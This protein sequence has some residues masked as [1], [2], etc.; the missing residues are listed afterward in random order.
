MNG[1]DEVL[2][3]GGER[4]PDG[5]WA[6]NSSVIPSGAQSPVG[7]CRARQHVG[8][9]AAPR[10]SPSPSPLPSPALSPPIAKSPTNIAVPQPEGFNPLLL[11]RHRFVDMMRSELMMID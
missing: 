1:G 4:H 11:V 5:A 2:G 6:G 3:N 9:G 8:R 10:R 7:V